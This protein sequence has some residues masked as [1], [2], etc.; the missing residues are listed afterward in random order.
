M[1][2]KNREAFTFYQPQGNNDPAYTAQAPVTLTADAPPLTPLMLDTSTGKLKV[3]DG[4]TLGGG[5]G[6]TAIAAKSSDTQVAYFKSGSFR[7]SDIQWPSAVT[8][9][10]KKRTAFV[11]TALSVV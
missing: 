2:T 6:L 4:T 10:D 1:S 11:G 3:W 7:L 5:V 9:D 8:E